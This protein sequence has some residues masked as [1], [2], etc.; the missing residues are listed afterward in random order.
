LIHIS[1]HGRSVLKVVRNIEE[2]IGPAI[3]GSDPR[4][5]RALDKRL[6][7][8]DG[9][10]N[11]ARL[12]ANATLAVS[13][14]VCRAGAS[15]L[16]IPLYR[17]LASL[18][19]NRKLILPVPSFNVINGGRHAGNALAFQEFMILP[20]GAS[21]FAEGLRMGAETY[22]TLKKLVCARYGSNACNVGD[23][24][25]FAP[26]GI[27][28]IEEGVKLVYDAI[29]EAGFEGRM[30]IGVDSA[31]SEFYRQTQTPTN[32]EGYY[33]LGFKQRE[34]G[35]GKEDEMKIV[36]KNTNRDTLIKSKAEM[37]ELYLNLAKNYPIAF[38]EDPFE[39]DDW[40]PAKSLT[41]A[42]ACL[43]IGDD[44]LCTNPSRVKKG[45]EFKCVNSLL[46]KLN[47]IGTISEAIEAVRLAKAAG[48]G[49][50]TSHR[51]GETEDTFIADLAVGLATGLIKT[52]APCR[53]ERTAK[54]NQL[55]RIEEELLKRGGVNEGK[56]AGE[57]EGTYAGKGELWKS[58]KW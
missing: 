12:G 24:G 2:I 18:A 51:S 50:M 28:S 36:Q 31:A 45:I 35:G 49:V 42:G 19:G 32:E 38:I 52:G 4:D 53:S 57:N 17:H 6:L 29:K 33:D 44:M 37:L 9:T 5:Q 21:S 48:W 46:L 55:L 14:A 47:Q 15:T 56:E 13:M 34:R 22:H 1:Y 43:V 8:L 54:Y 30:K 10:A 3:K 11:K 39:Q 16:N 26:A 25:G 27:V 58:I 41:A 40:E 23:E 20:I 7:E